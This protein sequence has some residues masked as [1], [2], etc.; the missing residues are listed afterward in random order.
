MQIISGNISIVE[1]EIEL[2][3]N[4]QEILIFEA[5]EIVSNSDDCIKYL[6]N[7]NVDLVL[8]DI[9]IKSNVDRIE[10]VQL[11]VSVKFIQY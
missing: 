1:A 8:I 7:N 11:S 10:T 2:A 4:Y 3:E 9:F 6:I 5:Y